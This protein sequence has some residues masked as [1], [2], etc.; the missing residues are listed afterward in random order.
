MFFS[1]IYVNMPWS[2]VVGGFSLY[3]IFAD[4]VFFYAEWA[5]AEVT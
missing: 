2:T 1:E 5:G 4:G 3:I